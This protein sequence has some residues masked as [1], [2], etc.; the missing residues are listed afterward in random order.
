MTEVFDRALLK[1]TIQNL[2]GTDT[3]TAIVGVAFQFSSSPQGE[4]FWKDIVAKLEAIR[5]EGHTHKGDCELCG[6]LITKPW[7]APA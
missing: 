4:D 7:V 2:T 3:G 1:Q 6:A 5:D